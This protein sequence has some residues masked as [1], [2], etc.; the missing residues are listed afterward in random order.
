MA[1]LSCIDIEKSIN[2]RRLVY[3][4][5]WL[6]ILDKIGFS[7]ICISI[8]TYPILLL[9]MTDLS[10]PNDKALAFT[11]LPLAILFGIYDFIKS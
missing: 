11:I 2:T 5:S 6:D 3:K 10:N 7:I 9:F 1:N 8:M 4:R